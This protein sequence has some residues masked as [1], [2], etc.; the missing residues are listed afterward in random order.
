MRKIV[1]AL[2]TLAILLFVNIS[3]VSVENFEILE[4]ETPDG[5]SDDVNITNVRTHD[6]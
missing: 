3:S 6:P 4:E 5:W 1:F 2:T